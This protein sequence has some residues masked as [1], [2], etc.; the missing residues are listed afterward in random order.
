MTPLG[1]I[2]ATARRVLTLAL[3]QGDPNRRGCS[4]AVTVITP[5]EPGRAG[6]LRKLLRQYKPGPPSPLAKVPDVQF[7]RWVIIDQLRTDWPGAP[8]PPPRL[9]SEYLLF[10]ADVTAPAYRVGSLPD[11]FFRDVATHMSADADKVWRHCLGYPGA[12]DVER[13]VEYMKKSQITIGLYYAAYPDATV[14]DVNH[15]LHV[16]IKLGEFALKAQDVTPTTAL[17]HEYLTR[18][19]SW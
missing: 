19:A 4:Y 11:S 17:R 5:I 16:R 1:Y 18:S 9:K 6:D 3:G 8:K 7:A 2:A 15:A 13:F 10:S 12:A 14:D